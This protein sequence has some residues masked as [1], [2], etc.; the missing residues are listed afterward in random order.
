MP[1]SNILFVTT[2]DVIRFMYQN[3]ITYFNLP[4]LLSTGSPSIDNNLE[5]FSKAPPVVLTP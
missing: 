5:T 2:H 1:G 3:G 4:Y